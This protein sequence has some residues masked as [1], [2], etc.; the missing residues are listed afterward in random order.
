MKRK[1][2]ISSLLIIT[3]ASA[4][5]GHVR[6]REGKKSGYD[7]TVAEIV[8]TME[9]GGCMVAFYSKANC[10]SCT[11]YWLVIEKMA[12]QLD[13]C[14]PVLDQGRVMD[15]TFLEEHDIWDSPALIVV[16]EGRVKGYEGI[17]DLET[18]KEILRYGMDM[19]EG[20]LPQ[21]L[22]ISYE[23][24]SE[25]MTEN[26]DFLLY[27]GRRDCLDCQSF[28]PILEGYVSAH[29]DAEVYYF[30]MKELRESSMGQNTR[31]EDIEAYEQL[32][33]RFDIQWVP[34]LY[35]VVNG[36]IISKYEYL[37]AEYYEIED[38]SRQKEERERF[39]QEFN[40]WMEVNSK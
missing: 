40:A 23:R 12:K 11:D 13:V 6:F 25:K 1:I 7:T 38:E 37:S 29:E 22:H 26:R 34:S 5:F 30:D 8:Q 20:R 28:Y 32:K 33:Q 2:L 19:T 39:L 24:L 3:V 21:I 14:V 15:P 36:T 10:S 9:N 31:Q 27:I 35:R 18:T 16:R 4:W 17:F